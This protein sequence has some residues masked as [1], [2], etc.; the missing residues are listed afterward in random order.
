ME[1]KTLYLGYIKNKVIEGWYLEDLHTDI[2]VETIKCDEELYL[3]LLSLGQAK[4]KDVEEPNFEKE[5]T[6]EDKERFEQTGIEAVNSAND[7]QRSEAETLLKLAEKEVQ[8]KELE[9][10]ID[11]IVEQLGVTL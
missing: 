6:I 11:K 5:Y 4:F 7:A 8:I 9:S 3:F 2:P 1:E 10:K